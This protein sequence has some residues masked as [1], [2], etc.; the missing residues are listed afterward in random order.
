M[1]QRYGRRTS[2]PGARIPQLLVSVGCSLVAF[3]GVWLWWFGQNT[4]GRVV[5]NNND[6]TDP[7]AIQLWMRR[8]HSFGSYALA[9]V[10]VFMIVRAAVQRDAWRA[11]FLLLFVIFV[12]IGVWA[13]ATADWDAA[14]LW[15]ETVGG[16]LR[17][18]FDMGNGPQLPDK[19][20]RARVHLSV[21]PVAMLVVAVLSLVHYRRN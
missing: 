2:G 6:I 14:R 19:L 5:R 12:G 16:K 17:A 18:G 7:F 15:S 11:I 20:R 4:T 13:G 21:V 9:A 1:T 8:L 3:T 10:I